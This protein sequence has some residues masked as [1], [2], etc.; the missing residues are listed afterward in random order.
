MGEAGA[1]HRAAR[2][3]QARRHAGALQALARQGPPASP[4]LTIQNVGL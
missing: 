2:E 3:T 4:A 1:E